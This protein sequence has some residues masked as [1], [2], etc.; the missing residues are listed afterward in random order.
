MTQVPTAPS[1]CRRVAWSP[2]RPPPF[3]HRIGAFSS[4]SEPGGVDAKDARAISGEEARRDRAGQDAHEVEH[5]D[6]GQRPFRARSPIPLGLAAA[7]AFHRHKRFDCYG[8]ALRM[9]SPGL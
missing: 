3:S 6:T 1:L 7:E 4:G 5:A 9:L 2:T 8:G